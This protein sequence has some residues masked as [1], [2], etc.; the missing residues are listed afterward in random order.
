MNA[1]L[2]AKLA[3]LKE[4]FDMSTCSPSIP[5]LRFLLLSLIALCVSLAACSTPPPAANAPTTHEADSPK[6]TWRYPDLTGTVNNWAKDY[7]KC[8]A[9]EAN[10]SPIILNQAG[11]TEGAKP[12]RLDPASFLVKLEA[13]RVPA[14]NNF[15]FSFTTIAGPQPT[16]QWNNMSWQFT[17]FHFHV[18]AEHVIVGAPTAV[19]EVHIKARVVGTPNRVGVF[20]IQ[21]A[22]GSSVDMSMAPVAAAMRGTAGQTLDF[23]SLLARFQD[24]P[25]FY[26]VGSL[27]TP[28]CDPSVPFFVL[29]KLVT[30][31]EASWQS[32]AT[33]LLTLNNYPSNARSLQTLGTRSVWYL[34]N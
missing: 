17:E 2:K 9:T 25:S 15:D 30:I 26:Y 5:G 10:Q 1:V 21:F 31:D 34:K 24:Q 28:G 13:R 3:L 32:I 22:I 27:T 29:Q 14:H 6:P 16:I 19:L 20:A 18:P 11:L 4:R 33:S 12:N 7:A 8:A 23:G